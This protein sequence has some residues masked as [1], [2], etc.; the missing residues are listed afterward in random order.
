[1]TSS[2]G[3]WSARLF[4]ETVRILV[5]VGRHPKVPAGWNIAARR[6]VTRRCYRGRLGAVSG[7]QA[8]L[9]GPRGGL[10]AVGGAELAQD[11]GHV[12]LTVSSATT[13]SWVMRWFDLPAAS[14]RSTSSSRPVSGSARPGGAAGLRPRCSEAASRRA[15]RPAA[16]RPRQPGPDAH[17][18][19]PTPVG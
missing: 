4:G 11:V 15:T 17:Y 18:L 8:E 1:M 14:S 9:P 5:A 3:R 2:I 7:D 12:L 19:G 16:P 10:G 13:R 6:S